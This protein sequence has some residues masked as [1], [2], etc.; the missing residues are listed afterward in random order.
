MRPSTQASSKLLVVLL[1]LLTGCSKAPAPPN[2]AP[3]SVPQAQDQGPDKGQGIPQAPATSGAQPAAPAAGA[4]SIDALNDAALT[5]I[6]AGKWL[7]AIAAAQ[8]AVQLDNKNPA[9]Q[10]N[11]GRAYLG[12]GHTRDALEIL[13]TASRLTGGKNPDVEYYRGQA[14][15]AADRLIYAHDIYQDALAAL[16]GPDKEIRAA[17]DAVSAKLGATAPARE[18]LDSVVQMG[19]VKVPSSGADQL[20]RFLLGPDGFTTEATSFT[21]PPDRNA[22]VVIGHVAA[23]VGQLNEGWSWIQWRDQDRIYLQ[24]IEE[25]SPIKV[26]GSVFIDGKDGRYLVLQLV[27]GMPPWSQYLRVLKLDPARPAW[28][29]ADVLPAFPEKLGTVEL[30]K[31][32]GSIIASGANLSK[33]DAIMLEDGGRTIKICDADNK[34][35]TAGWDGAR[36]S[37]K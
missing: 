7:E 5:A 23:N 3:V 31:G 13:E 36:Y 2:A 9:A 20:K 25:Q 1:L 19:D 10:F 14:A 34:C 29:K 37:L 26:A 30:T 16:P 12:A 22:R 21:A 15:E 28:V 18:K 17:L 6:R 24:T 11:L 4:P 32:T 33:F 35:L 27:L 8:Q